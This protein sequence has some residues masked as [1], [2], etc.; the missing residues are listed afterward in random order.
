MRKSTAGALAGAACLSLALAACGGVASGGSNASGETP[1]SASAAGNSDMLIGFSMR[2]ISGV[3]WY[4]VLV[5]GAKAQA[6]KDGVR[7]VVGDAESNLV[8]QN[9]EIQ[10]YIS[11]GAKAVIIN[12]ADPKGV[13]SSITALGQQHIPFVVVNSNLD[14]ELQA[15][16][17]CFVAENQTVASGLSGGAVAAKLAEQG[18]G[19][20]DITGVQVGGFPGEVVTELRSNGFKNAMTKWFNAHGDH[21]NI[22][23]LPIQYAQW[24]DDKPLTMIRDVATGHPNLNFVYAES[25]NMVPGVLQGLKQGGITQAVVAGYNGQTSLIKQMLDDP[26]GMLQ[27]ESTDG[28]FEQGELAVK[29]AEAAANG[30]DLT[31]ECPGGNHFVESVLVTPDNAKQWYHPTLQFVEPAGVTK[32]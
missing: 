8:T 9:S 7:L 4:Q 24:T 22:T 23:W 5:D 28:P 10:S 1:G 26:T 29:Y 16:A 2:A 3:A 27:A 17:E 21:P 32:D 13:A 25:D 20:A 30:Q 19:K 15:K 14:K 6:A 12:P 11:Q 18:L 31:S